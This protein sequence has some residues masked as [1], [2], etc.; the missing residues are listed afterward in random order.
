MNVFCDNLKRFRIAR[1]M[2]QEQ[3]AEKLGLQFKLIING[4]QLL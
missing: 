2:T 3:A 4:Q 1:N